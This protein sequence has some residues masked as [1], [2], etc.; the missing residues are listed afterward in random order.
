MGLT[1][2]PRMPSAP[3]WSCNTR[4]VYITRLKRGNAAKVKTVT[5]V[6]YMTLLTSLPRSS[7]LSGDPDPARFSQGTNWKRESRRFGWRPRQSMTRQIAKRKIR[8]GK[9]KLIFVTLVFLNHQEFVFS[10]F[11]H[12][13]TLHNDLK[14]GNFLF[15]D[16]CKNIRRLICLN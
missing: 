5:T 2:S 10:L 7:T 9:P 4:A 13:M 16:A 1:T 14:Y 15:K 8:Q 3:L 6:V 11:W 12:V